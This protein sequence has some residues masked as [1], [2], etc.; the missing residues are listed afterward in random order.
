VSTTEPLTAVTAFYFILAQHRLTVKLVKLL[1]KLTITSVSKS[2]FRIVSALSG[3]AVASYAHIYVHNIMND[4]IIV[5]IT[6]T[7][8]SEEL[9]IV[10]DHINTICPIIQRLFGQNKLW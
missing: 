10:H 1:T 9:L 8:G 5:K 6:S 3:Q 4:R 2:T 7:S